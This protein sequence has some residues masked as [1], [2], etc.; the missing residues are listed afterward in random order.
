V[1]SARQYSFPES[2]MPESTE[3]FSSRVDNYVRYRPS[4]P[5]AAIELLQRRCGLNPGAVVAD[6]GSGTGILTRLLL[7]H[8]AKVA[9]VEPND[10]M[11]AAAEAAL[12]C[13]PRFV[14]VKGTAE[15]TTLSDASVDLVVAGQAFHWFKVGPARAEA[16]RIARRGACGA[17]LWNEHPTGGSPFLAD[18]ERLLRRH[19]SEYDA[20]V[21][22]RVDE[23]AMR[24]F[25]GASMQCATFPN[26]QSFDYEGLLG[27]LMSSSYAP[28]AGHPEHGP[29]LA[30]IAR[31]FAAHE[32]GGRI[33]FPYVTLVYFAQ[34]K[35]GA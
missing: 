4:Y 15:S 1:S 27:R 20:V 22:S 24:E 12:T 11:R 18:Y 2:D 10:P 34:L 21:G 5:P 3:R 9:A 16:L 31:L 14:S 7:P 17:L 23:P 33:L 29:L 13:D 19:A 8:A 6:L 30:G 26:Q 35:A 25:L 32:Q 28:E